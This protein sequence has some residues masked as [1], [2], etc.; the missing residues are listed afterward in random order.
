MIQD[1]SCRQRQG[2]TY[3]IVGDSGSGKSTLARAILGN[4]QVLKGAIIIGD[5]DVRTVAPSELYRNVLYVPRSTFLLEGAVLENIDFFEAETLAAESALR[6]ALPKDL[7][8]AQVG[9]DRGK[10]MFGGEMTRLS[11]ARAFGSNASVLIFDESTSGL[12][13]NT[14]AK[15][16]RLIKNITVKTVLVITHNWN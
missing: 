4:V 8:G 13:P 3:A 14:A 16:E 1:F 12:D 10:N 15:I 2:G 7:L 9:E 5:V 6:A 11:I